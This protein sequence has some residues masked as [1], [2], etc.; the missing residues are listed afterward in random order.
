MNRSCGIYILREISILQKTKTV[1]KKISGYSESHN[2]K[3]EEKTKT[4]ELAQKWIIS[5][6]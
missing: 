1:I 6:A 5:V 4:A 2:A 3:E